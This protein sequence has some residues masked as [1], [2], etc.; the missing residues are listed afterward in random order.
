MLSG[1]IEELCLQIGLTVISLI[2]DI[3]TRDLT[4]NAKKRRFH[5]LHRLVSRF[6]IRLAFVTGRVHPFNFA[7]LQDGTK[8]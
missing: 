6:G 4:K 1:T 7:T 3:L 8:P 5:S 2:L